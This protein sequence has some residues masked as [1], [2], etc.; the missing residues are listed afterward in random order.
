MRM[1]TPITLT[2]LVGMALA[3]CSAP[4]PYQTNPNQNTN[5]GMATGAA[6]VA[7]DPSA[8]DAAVVRALEVLAQL[9][10]RTRDQQLPEP[11]R[12]KMKPFS[13]RALTAR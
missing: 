12:R 6:R 5:S 1:N 11:E 10:R 2:I 4:N 13:P 8:R 3:G 7:L 9:A